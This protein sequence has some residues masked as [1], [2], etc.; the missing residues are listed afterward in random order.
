MKPGATTVVIASHNRAERLVQTLTKL[1]SLDEIDGIVVADNGSNDGTVERLQRE[2]PA[3]RCMSLDHNAGAFARTVAVATVTTPYVAFC[4]DDCWWTPS[5]IALGAAMLDRYADVG[6]INAR[7]VVEPDGRLDPACERMALAQPDERPGLPIAFFMAGAVMMRTRTFLECGGYERRFGIGAEELLLAL[8]L[9]RRGWRIRYVPAMEVRHAP[10]SVSRDPGRRQIALHRN[11]LW[12]AWM[13]YRGMAALR[14]TLLTARRAR[15][16]VLARRALASA[17]AGLPWTL[18]RR[19]P[20]AS[21]LQ[22]T[23][24]ALAE[25][26]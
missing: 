13:R 2:H 18:A 7:V 11:R 19:T 10:S 15:H 25:A 9:H 17:L 1:S 24:D 22:R 4:D 21:D 3:V 26:P 5:S 20:V 6:A 8:D 12:I 16:D 14:A 23:I